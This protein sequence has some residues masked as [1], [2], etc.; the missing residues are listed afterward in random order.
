MKKKINL[1]TSV[2]FIIIFKNIDPINLSLNM[3][4]YNINKNIIISN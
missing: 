2:I 1:L 3:K 4:F